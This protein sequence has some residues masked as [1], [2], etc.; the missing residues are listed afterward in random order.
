MHRVLQCSAALFRAHHGEMT[1]C[2]LRAPLEDPPSLRGC[3]SE[4]PQA[5]ARSCS[6]TCQEPETTAWRVPSPL[7][8]PVNK[9]T[10]YS[11]SSRSR[12]KAVNPDCYM[13]QRTPAP[14]KQS[15]CKQT[16]VVETFICEFRHP[17]HTIPVMEFHSGFKEAVTI[18]Q[19]KY[20]ALF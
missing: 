20:R 13:A 12:R 4:I 11:W 18:T 7:P 15:S 16:V 3:Q 8:T 2:Q 9:G 6:I 19:T 10:L 1:K 14:A 5:E 17:P